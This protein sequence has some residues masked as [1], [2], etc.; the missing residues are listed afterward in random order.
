MAVLAKKKTVV[1]TMD[2]ERNELAIKLLSL[3]DQSIIHTFRLIFDDLIGV[4]KTQK[5]A[6]KAS[7]NKEVDAALKRVRNGKFVSNDDVMNEMDKW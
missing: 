7:Y 2:Q 1:Q 6:T 3:N 4:S 5:R